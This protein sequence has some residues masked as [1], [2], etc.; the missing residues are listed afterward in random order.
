MSKTKKQVTYQ[1]RTTEE[2]KTRLQLIAKALNTP[3]PDLLVTGAMMV[4]RRATSEA[5][6]LK[7][8][9]EFNAKSTSQLNN[10]KTVEK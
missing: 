9:A 5:E 2:L 8:K 6:Y 7:L 4:F 3:L 10:G 1:F